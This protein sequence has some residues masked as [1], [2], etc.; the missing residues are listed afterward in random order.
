[1]IVGKF[2]NKFINVFTGLF[3]IATVVIMFV[4]YLNNALPINF[5][6]DKAITL[7]H[8]RTYFTLVTV[9][10]AGLEF[11]LKRNVFLAVIFAAIIVAVAAFMLYTDF[12]MQI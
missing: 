3:G 7:G 6:G 10:C 9:F 1:M 12:G 5:L 2:I 4:I 11:T 8:Y